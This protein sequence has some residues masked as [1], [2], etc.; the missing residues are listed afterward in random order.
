MT[1]TVIVAGAVTDKLPLVPVTVTVYVPAVVPA[2]TTFEQGTEVAPPLH[3]LIAP[4]PNPINTTRLSPRTIRR[5]PGTISNKSPAKTT[6]IPPR[7]FAAEFVRQ[8]LVGPADVNEIVAVPVPPPASVKLT[9]A[10]P[11]VGGCAVTGATEQ[12]SATVPANPPTDFPVSAHVLV[13]VV[14]ATGV[15]DI[16]EGAAVSVKLPTVPPPT[17]P[18]ALPAAPMK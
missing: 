10:T 17:P 9:G 6:P 2:D 16:A 4:N 3:P 18:P 11:H 5:R 14:F 7:P 15:T 13:V 8:L 12:L 1:V